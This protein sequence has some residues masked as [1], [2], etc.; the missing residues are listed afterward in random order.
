MEEEYKIYFIYSQKGKKSNIAKL[1]LNEQIKKIEKISEGIISNNIYILYCL[2]IS[3]K[4]KEKLT[5]L[6]L[7]D[8]QGELYSAEISLNKDKPFLS[9]IFFEPYYDNK[10]DNS[11]NQILLP[12]QEQYN[13][14]KNNLKNDRKNLN[15][16]YLNEIDALMDQKNAK[17]HFTI[18]F[19]FF[20]ELYLKYNYIN[21]LKNIIEKFFEILNLEKISTYQENKELEIAEGDLNILSDV[22]KNRKNL[23]LITNN[24]EVINEKI[25]VFLGYY[26]LF[27]KPKLFISFINI[28]NESEKIHLHL[29]SNRNIFKDFSLEI[30]NLN[31]MEET[32]NIEEIISLMSLL[33]NMV[34][35]FNMLSDYDFFVKLCYLSQIELK[36]IDI[37]K[38]HKPKKD[39]NIELLSYYYYKMNDNFLKEYVMPVAI[40]KDFFI[41]YCKLFVDEDINKIKIFK[42]ILDNYNKNLKDNFK[43]KIE[44]EL[45]NYYY[46]SGVHLINNRKLKNLDLIDFIKNFPEYNNIDSLEKCIIFEERVQ[47]FIDDFLN[48]NFYDYKLID[49][50]GNNYS[51]LIKKIFDRFILPK[52]LLIIKDWKISEYAPEEVIQ[53]FLESLK[54]IWLN[55]PENF[56][57]GL[58]TL[59]AMEFGIASLNVINFYEIIN[60]LQNN[61][62][63]DKILVMYSKLLSK[64]YPI[65]SQFKEH[66][67]NFININKKEGPLSIWYTVT[68]FDDHYDKFNYLESNLKE[69]YAVRTEDFIH[70]P[71]K[72]EDRITL[73]T[74][75]Y[76]AECFEDYICET[77]YYI[78][79]IKSKDNFENLKFK[80]I[81]IIFKNILEFPNLLVFFIPGRF[82]EENYIIIESTLFD[83]S[84]KCVEAKTH[85]ESLKTVQNYWNRFFQNEK[86]FERNKLKKNIIEYENSPLKD[87]NKI[88]NQTKWVLDFLNEAKEGEKLFE[89]I[90]FMEIYDQFKN[91]FD[92]NQERDRYNLSYKKFNDLKILGK[93][94][95]LNLLDLNLKDI[96]V[97]AAYKNFEKINDELN[98]IKTYFNFDNKS[99]KGYNNYNIR[100][101]HRSLIKLVL[102][103]QDEHGIYKINPDDNLDYADDEEDNKN[104]ENIPLNDENYNVE[105]D[106]DFSL[107]EQETP[108]KKKPQKENI[109]LIE[110]KVSKTLIEEQK[111]KLINE[112]YSLS[113]IFF[114]NSNIF[115][116][117]KYNQKNIMDNNQLRKEK[118]EIYK[119][120]IQFFLK[121]IETN[122]GFAKLNDNEFFKEIISLANKIYLN[123]INL[124][125]FDEPEEKYKK[126]LILIS[127]LNDVLKTFINQRKIKKGIFFRLLEKFQDCIKKKDLE[128]KIIIES[129]DNLL[130]E[131]N[132]N[133]EK[134]K[135]INL[136]IEL[137]IKERKLIENDAELINFILRDGNSNFYYLYNNLIPII[138]EIFQDELKSKLNFEINNNNENYAI[139]N[140]NY[141]TKINEKIKDSK[142]LEELLL[143]YFE[144]KIINSLNKKYNKEK[145]NEKEISKDDQIKVCLKHCFEFLEKEYFQKLGTKTN[146]NISILYCIAYIKSFLNKFITFI[147]DNYQHIDNIRGI[148]NIIK[149]SSSN[150]FRTSFELYILKLFFQ[151]AGNYYDYYNLD[152]KGMYEI[153]FITDK[154]ISNFIKDKLDSSEKDYGFDYKIIPTKEEKI[155]YFD[156]MLNELKNIKKFNVNNNIDDKNLL[157]TINNNY[158]IDTFYCALLNIHFSFFYNKI[159][160]SSNE[161]TMFH[162]WLQSKIEKNEFII[163][164]NNEIIK[165]IFIFISKKKT[166]NELNYFFNYNKL[167]CLLISA[168]YVLT[169]LSFNN[170]N[171]LFYTLLTNP[172]III[173]NFSK[174]FT[175]YLKDFNAYNK[176]Q[177]D[178]NYLTYK[179]INYIILSYLYFGYILGI[180]NLDDI[181]KL[182][183]FEIKEK[184]EKNIPIRIFNL[185][186]DEFNFI[187]KNILNLIGIKKNI[188]FMNSIFDDIS[189]I[190]INIKCNNDEIYIKSEE[191]N[192]DNEINKRISHFNNY[193]EEYYRLKDFNKG[194]EEDLS[195]FNNIIF[196]KKEYF[197]KRKENLNNICPYMS[198]LTYTNFCIFDDFKNQFLY[199]NNDNYNNF[200]LIKS[201]L[202]NDNILDLINCIPQINL[203]INN[204]YNEL[205]LKISKDDINKRI[206]DVLSEKIINEIDIFNKALDKIYN[207]LEKKD[208]KKIDKESLISEVINI[209][210]NNINNIYNEIIKKYNQFLRSIKIFKDNKDEVSPIIIQ[211]A[212][213]NDYISFTI[214]RRNFRKNDNIYYQNEQNNNKINIKNRLLE[215]IQ[216]YSK[217]NRINNNKI[218]IYDGGKIN[219]DYELIENKLEEEYILGKKIFENEQKLFIFSNEIFSGKRNNILIEL[220]R[221]NPQVEINKEIMTK[222]EESINKEDI[223]KI[224]R[225]LQYIILNNYMNKYEL[226]NRLNYIIKILEKSNYSLSN[227]FNNLLSKFDDILSLNNIIYLYEKIELKVF[228]EFSKD[229]KLNIN[230]KDK[231]IKKE[232]KEKIENILNN[233]EIIIT[234]DIFI[235]AAKKYILRYCIGDNINKNNILNNFKNGNELFNRY[236]IWGEKL[237]KDE[238]FMDKSNK[239]KKINGEKNYLIKYILND[240]FY[241]DENNKLEYEENEEEDEELEDLKKSKKKKKEKFEIPEE[242]EKKL[243]I[244]DEDE[245][246]NNYNNKKHKKF[247]LDNEDDDGEL[248]NFKKK[249][250]KFD[251]E[252]E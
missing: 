11:L 137:F 91:Q 170:N 202:N 65:S 242:N 104:N 35:C 99:Q 220:S 193:V 125:L 14:F 120:F 40:K 97:N 113:K 32:K 187:E 98:F 185:L 10:S 57:Y 60:V 119:S 160:L 89:S 106:D 108:V 198:Y 147:Y 142:D 111:M 13:I 71:W 192:L 174:Y 195:I 74:N 47:K 164:N 22:E 27:Y 161:C 19:K 118:D 90:F 244:E 50:L 9:Y 63:V 238:K 184:E 149:G 250:G 210:N 128:V 169:T 83:F 166:E 236:D 70:Y 171:G 6:T 239:L 232:E 7:I 68:T 204:V 153:Y 80:D 157:D 251:D 191:Q 116:I 154:D 197:I 66:V 188:I 180:L 217:R 183:S 235:N 208:F 2:T 200:T 168:R 55:H 37:M 12:L 127:Q 229:I 95:D 203:F 131:M 44:S 84:D 243:E 28:K 249:K 247:D 1:E 59:I 218:N 34:D 138:N 121:I 72:I 96:L 222:I 85:Y 182:L 8:N 93:I 201:I 172:N 130:T 221:N 144:T 86:N 156:F 141:L 46:R 146:K 39:D 21:E 213:E 123:G 62:S 53:I 139:F 225:N 209:D 61:I 42:E 165:N 20:M 45:N 226:N 228:D 48:D 129:L 87:Y 41:E 211:N 167:L 196:E 205:V 231:E 248:I 16:L 163:L 223:L 230:K 30:I 51:K 114:S 189:S 175:Y 237:F 15:N 158:D 78:K 173:S 177:R 29:I 75:L 26:Y 31:L 212:S 206:G 234:K 102:K 64:K 145:N 38:I 143:F 101:I 215:L 252:D 246:E 105:D 190:I 117:E 43:I 94:S 151:N 227:A 152:L 135:L 159:Y 17:I 5:T 219:Y 107:F 109:I 24:K 112:I 140:S 133:I 115:I 241:Q 240:I 155:E 52:D 88:Y 124:C 224:Y 92:R 136:Y 122:H 58:E 69:E 49:I 56:M 233:K 23:I 79:S 245:D 132:N 82:K 77:D 148:I 76:N 36:V 33:P 54:R 199:F 103:Y 186:F 178:I 207:I 216:I 181:N 179:I 81:M 194:V 110:K 162:N 176:E 3:N 18:L 126:E 4:K 134:I 100:V 150:S 73:F 25:D 214:N 67:I